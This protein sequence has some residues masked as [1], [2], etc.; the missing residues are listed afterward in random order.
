MNIEI[1]NR[2]VEFRKKNGLSQEQLAEK[3]GVS[4]QAVSK[5]E[6]SE[7]SPDTDNLILLARLYNVSLDE[8]LRTEDEIPMPEPQ[9]EAEPPQPE[10]KADGFE[11]EGEAQD[12]HAKNVSFNGGIHVEDGD[13]VVHIGPDGIHVKE[14]SGDSVHVGWDGIHVNGNGDN[15]SVSGNGVYVNGE[16]V[17]CCH[18]KA[19]VWASFPYAILVIIAF[20]CLGFVLNAWWWAWLLFL[21]VPVFHGTVEAI[22]KRKLWKFPYEIVTVIAFLCMGMFYGWWHPGWVV[23]LT[24]PVFRWICSMIKDS[25]R[26]K[27]NAS[28]VEIDGVSVEPDSC[29]ETF[30]TAFDDK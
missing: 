14:K 2:L 26:K 19:C 4:R 28:K 9:A 25:R 15:V 17:D 6:R 16:R 7:A 20:L 23:F 22:S 21:T 27:K 1:A 11:N 13:D 29:G 5:W 24:I 12:N 3:I 10:E 18:K 8:L 30:S